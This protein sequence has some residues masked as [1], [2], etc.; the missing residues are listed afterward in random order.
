MSELLEAISSL[1]GIIEAQNSRINHLENNIEVIEK[2]IESNTSETEKLK[3]IIAELKADIRNRDQDMLCNDIE[4]TH[5]PETQ[6]ENTVHVVL[7]IAKKINVR[8]DERDVVF[9]ERVG[10]YRP[11][12]DK[13]APEKPRPLMLR[14]SRRATRDDIIKAARVC[15]SITTEGMSLPGPAV[16]FYINERLTNYKRRLFHTT[17]KIAKEE[18][19]KYVWTRNGKIFIRR[20]Q[21]KARHEV[22]AENCLTKIF[23]YD[24][25]ASTYDKSNVINA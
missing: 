2:K 1:S 9:A 18:K 22:H 16:Y 25:L 23:G 6:N 24:P 12:A 13:L 8:L 11:T 21:G 19:W 17:R 3:A 15:R 14:L 4:I 20:E 5:L 7:A 10:Y